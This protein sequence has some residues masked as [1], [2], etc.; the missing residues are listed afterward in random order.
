M[1]SR[2]HQVLDAFLPSWIRILH[3]NHTVQIEDKLC[4]LLGTACERMY[5]MSSV[6]RCGL[7]AAI[8]HCKLRAQHPQLP[9]KAA[10]HTPGRHGREANCTKTQRRGQLWLRGKPAS[11]YREVVVRFPGHVEVSFGKIL[12]PKLLLMC[13]S[14]PCMEAT[15]MSVW[16]YVWIT[17]SHFGQERLLNALNVNVN[18]EVCFRYKYQ[19]KQQQLFDIRWITMR[20]WTVCKALQTDKRFVFVVFMKDA[21]FI[22]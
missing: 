14:G 9:F 10:T 17:V 2:L 11:R 7:T 3:P 20:M 6:V 13:W 22:L 16:M 15:A 19:K 8:K 18:K 4:S 12:N 21:A 5:S 1:T